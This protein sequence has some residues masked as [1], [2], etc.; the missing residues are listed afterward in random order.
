M[1]NT[2]EIGTT[3]GG[4]R[5]V[6][7]KVIGAGGFGIT[8]Y[9]RHVELN[10]H[11]AVKEFFISGKC[12]RET[13]RST[14]FLQDIDPGR[15]A[16]LKKRFA[17]E[18]RTLVVL[19]NP[20]VVRV[21]DIFDENNTSYI[22]MEYVP[23]INLQQKIENEGP[24]SFMDAMN[25]MGQ[26]AEAVSYIHEKHILH[27]D[28][29]PDNVIITPDN[30]VVLIDFGSAREFVHDEVQNQTA[31][32]TQGYAPPEQYNT[33]SK[34]GNYTDIYAL[35]G[36]FYFL[37]TGVKP[38]DATAR[39]MEPLREPKM[40][41]P[42]ISSKTSKTIMKAMELKPEN[43]YQ[44]V[45]DFMNDLFGEV[46]VTGQ[47]EGKGGPMVPQGGKERKSKVWLWVLLGVLVLG[48][49]VAAYF[50]I[51]RLNEQARINHQQAL[52]ME[53]EEARE[54]L[55]KE[56]RKRQ[57]EEQERIDRFVQSYN[58]KAKNCM[59]D[60]NTIVENRDQ[61]PGDKSNWQNA[62]RS[63]QDLERLEQDPDFKKT[64]LTPLYQ[65]YYERF[66]SEL[67]ED[68]EKANQKFIDLKKQGITEGSLYTVYKERTIFMESIY[69]QIGSGSA[70][71]IRY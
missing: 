70:A 62:L 31:I 43:R 11:Y 39:M 33:T 32:L 16:K 13:D 67:T 26:L 48:G 20:H 25:C 34:K 21:I 1:S 14:V 59:A 15:Y 35:G 44:S 71:D 66:V 12:V 29:K 2:L 17:D 55:Q 38:I 60:L 7:E 46:S 10:A 3:F 40:L 53:D 45:Q 9:V 30:R 19:N 41:N 52:I 4:G 36:V 8:Y 18:A 51:Q 57:K 50:G 69:S 49:G 27:R 23:G 54:K 56:E 24:M 37:L 47:F 64:G 22:V 42:A 28:I 58:D 61:A 68:R 63:L 5:Y 6:V 65:K